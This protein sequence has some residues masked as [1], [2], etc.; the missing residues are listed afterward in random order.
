M[1]AVLH[2]MII[3]SARSFIKCQ[4]YVVNVTGSFVI[5]L[6]YLEHMSDYYIKYV[7]EILEH[8]THI[9]HKTLSPYVRYKNHKEF[10]SDWLIR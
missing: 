10:A 8:W 1:A 9:P 4:V 6:V 2:E 7:P 5:T 3:C